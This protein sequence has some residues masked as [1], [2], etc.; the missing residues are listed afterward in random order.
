MKRAILYTFPVVVGVVIGYLANL[1]MPIALANGNTGISTQ[2]RERILDLISHYSHAWDNKDSEAWVALYADEAISQTYAA[3]RLLGEA[4]TNSERLT[5]AQKRHAMF[6]EN[7]IQTR[8]IQ[9]NTLLSPHPDGSVTGKTVF[10]VSWQYDGDKVPKLMHTGLYRDKF[11][12][13]SSG[14]KFMR[15][16]VRVDHQ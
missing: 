5:H 12:E 7:G 1:L 15:R 13:T 9:T 10:L 2:D 14:W 3:G 8:H 11:V 6:A 16:E 4:L